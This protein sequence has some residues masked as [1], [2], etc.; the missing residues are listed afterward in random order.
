LEEKKRKEEVWYRFPRR[1]E[2]TS[3]SETE[4]K[5]GGV[6]YIF[7]LRGGKKSG[8]FPTLSDRGK[9]GEEVGLTIRRGG[10]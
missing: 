3:A 6:F 2:R 4:R 9:R 1:L 8:K 10:E 7:L 5:K